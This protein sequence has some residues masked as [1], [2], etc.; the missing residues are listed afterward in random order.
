MHRLI[1][2]KVGL[3]GGGRYK[4]SGLVKESSRE[5]RAWPG[6]LL[7]FPRTKEMVSRP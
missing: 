5:C 6:A 2:C 4:W 7:L 3:S 1:Q